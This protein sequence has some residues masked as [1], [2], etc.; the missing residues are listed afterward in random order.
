[1]TDEPLF[2]SGGSP[3]TILIFEHLGHLSVSEAQR[4]LRLVEE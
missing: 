1:M 4:T 3:V 2:G